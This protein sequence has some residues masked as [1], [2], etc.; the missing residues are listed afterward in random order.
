MLTYSR[1][2]PELLESDK[3]FVFHKEIFMPTHC[4]ENM[5]VSKVSD[6]AAFGGRETVRPRP[7]DGRNPA[8]C[9]NLLARRDQ[10]A[11]YF[12]VTGTQP[13]PFEN[14]LSAAFQFQPWS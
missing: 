14:V 10:V 8:L 4:P 11:A 1:L 13:H 12:C 9:P 2:L 6:Q 3:Y 5:M 7:G